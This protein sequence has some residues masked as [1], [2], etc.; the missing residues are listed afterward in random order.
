MASGRTARR[1]LP[2]RRSPGG[3]TLL[4]LMIS[5]ALLGVILAMAY[6]AFSTALAAVPR[7]ERALD[8][9]ARLRMASSILARQVRS[10]VNYP[11]FTDD[12]VHPYFWGEPT[13]FGFITAAPQRRGGEGLGW[14]TYWLTDEGALAMAERSVFSTRSVS[15]DEPERSSETVLL[16]GI[17]GARFEYLRLEGDESEWVGRWDSL[18][19]QSL[20][21][22][23][24]VT[25]EG[26][27]TGGSAW[28]QEIPVVAVVYGL[29]AYDAELGLFDD[30]DR[31]GFE[32]EGDEE[33]F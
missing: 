8:R 12:E 6:S 24:R 9:A 1:A 25:L 21:G 23:I 19:E 32:D 7:G 10:I 5:L 29:G 13:S 16:D 18:E 28:I 3:F 26:V 22:A 4:E 27:G 31:S 20:P 33:G 17:E 2:G 14:V 11:A 15:G 30:F